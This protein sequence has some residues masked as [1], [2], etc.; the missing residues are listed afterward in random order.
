MLSAPSSPARWCRFSGFRQV[1]I[2]VGSFGACSPSRFESDAGATADYNEGSAEQFGFATDDASSV[3]P[4]Q[5][6][7]RTVSLARRR[8]DGETP[9]CLASPTSERPNSLLSVCMGSL[10]ATAPRL[11]LRSRLNSKREL[12]TERNGSRDA[13]SG[14]NGDA[15]AVPSRVPD[16]QVLSG[17]GG[18]RRPTPTPVRRSDWQ[19]PLVIPFRA[20]R[21]STQNG[22]SCYRWWTVTHTAATSCMRWVTDRITTVA[23]SM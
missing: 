20:S 16:T 4:S 19:R 9:G 12:G 14:R 13:A 10:R 11:A 22:T 1:R 18:L 15:C 21:V 17:F 6:A 2:T 8:G 5:R 23:P 3:G 7:S